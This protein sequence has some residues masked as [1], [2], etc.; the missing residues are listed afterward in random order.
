MHKFIFSHITKCGGVSIYSTFLKNGRMKYGPGRDGWSPDAD[1]GRA[2]MHNTLH[3]Y[4]L[5]FERY[6]Q[7]DNFNKFFKFAFVRNPWDRAV[8]QYLFRKHRLEKTLRRDRRV[9]GAAHHYDSFKIWINYILS[10][11]FGPGRKSHNLSI[12]DFHLGNYCMLHKIV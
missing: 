12:Q 3:G 5:V 4:R 2:D 9:F 10:P 6:D 11:D 7:A 1:I 8:S